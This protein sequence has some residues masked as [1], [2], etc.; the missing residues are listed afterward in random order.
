MLKIKSLHQIFNPGNV[1]QIHA[2]R[3]IDLHVAEKQFVTIIG[4]NGAGKSTLFN[5]IA[6]VF[7]ITSGQITI[8]QEDVTAWKEHQRGAI[9]GRVFQDPLLGTASQGTIAQNLTLA[10][11]RGK[12]H[13][14]RTG[15]TKERSQLFREVLA[16]LSLGLEHRLNSRVALL[17]GGQRQALTM[18]IATITKPKI[19]LLDE[20]TASLDPATAEKILEQT[21]QIVSGQNL[22]TLMITHNMQHALVFGDRILM[23]DNGQIVLDLSAEEKSGLVIQDLIEM[24]RE[25]QHKRILDDKILLTAS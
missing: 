17:S 15:V 21:K 25:V 6:G 14:L 11:L 5:A 3:G 2:L 13:R 19:L 8:D 4:S 9:I 22:T 23:M 20:H 10:L 18:L 24:F 12:Q 16:T 1:N 7:P